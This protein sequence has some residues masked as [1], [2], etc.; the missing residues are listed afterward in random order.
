MM[1]MLLLLAGV[2]GVKCGDESCLC[3]C[4]VITETT[5]LY[6]HDSR[7]QVMLQL[8]KEIKNKGWDENWW[9][10]HSHSDCRI[11]LDPKTA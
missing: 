1:L 9:R 10:Y 8:K 11:S 2:L 3:R 5:G 7:T 4:T 6:L